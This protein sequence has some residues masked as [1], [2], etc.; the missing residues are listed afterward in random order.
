MANPHPPQRR[1]IVDAGRGAQVEAIQDAERG[2]VHTD[3]QRERLLEIADRCPVKQTLERG[4]GI[5]D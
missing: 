5:R 1:R 2:R 4:V 3:A